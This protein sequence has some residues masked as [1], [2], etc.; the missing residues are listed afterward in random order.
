MLAVVFLLVVG[1]WW[2]LFAGDCGLLVLGDCLLR[3]ECFLCVDC[4]HPEGHD[5]GSGDHKSC[6][7]SCNSDRIDMTAV[8]I[9]C[10]VTVGMLMLV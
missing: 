3:V 9:L 1:C 8:Y 2:L 7:D 4:Y 10:S 6:E 5:S